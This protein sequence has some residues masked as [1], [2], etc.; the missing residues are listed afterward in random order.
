M[1][2]IA[3][4]IDMPADFVALRHEATHEELPAEQRIVAAC[5]A[6][7]KW[8]WRVYWSRLDIAQTEREQPTTDV[9]RND[10]CK[11]FAQKMFRSYRSAKRESLKKKERPELLQQRLAESIDA[12]AE[13]GGNDVAALSAVANDIV[14]KRLLIPTDREYVVLFMQWY[15]FADLH[16]AWRSS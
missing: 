8:L 15:H 12:F 14:E 10:T 16:Q 7:L 4:Q 11:A 9:E 1:L 13:L 2:E 6:A 5:E 3:R